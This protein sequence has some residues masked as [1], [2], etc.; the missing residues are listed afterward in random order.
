VLFVLCIFAGSQSN[1]PSSV[2]VLPFLL[3]IHLFFVFYSIKIELRDR[4]RRKLGV[5][6][7]GKIIDKIVKRGRYKYND[8]EYRR[9]IYLIVEYVH[10][11]TGKVKRFQTTSVNCCPYT[12]LS[13]LDVT[14]YEL[15]DGTAWATDFQ[16]I[17][18]LKDAVNYK[19][20][21]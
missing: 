9:T 3:L 7:K 6:C 4:K 16:R 12:Y 14:V 15:P 13:S 11:Q 17:K 1:E 5:K 18:T 21:K 19:K 20:R 2:Y 10:S 8:M